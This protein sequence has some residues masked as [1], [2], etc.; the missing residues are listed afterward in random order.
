MM[1]IIE[2]TEGLVFPEPMSLLEVLCL[3]LRYDTF[4]SL[5]QYGENGEVTLLAVANDYADMLA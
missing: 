3:C 2:L 1:Y 4:I 5:A